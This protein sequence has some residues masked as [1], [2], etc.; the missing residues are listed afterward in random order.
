MF[1]YGVITYI[2]LF[3]MTGAASWPRKTPVE[4]DHASFK[5]ATF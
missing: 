4:K 3:A 2:V 5:L 1:G